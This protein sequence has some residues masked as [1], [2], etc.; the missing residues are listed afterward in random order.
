M[1]LY[2][3]KVKKQYLECICR[4]TAPLQKTLETQPLKISEPKKKKKPVSSETG[5]LQKIK[6]KLTQTFNCIL[7]FV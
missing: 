1:I 5:F 7:D 4:S 3:P 2:I 6:N